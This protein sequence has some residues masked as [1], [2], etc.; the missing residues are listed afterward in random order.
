MSRWMVVVGVSVLM[1]GTCLVAATLARGPGYT[2]FAEAREITCVACAS[3]PAAPPGESQYPTETSVMTIDGGPHLGKDGA[4]AAAEDAQTAAEVFGSSAEA[5]EEQAR[6]TQAVAQTSEEGSENVSADPREPAGAPEPG[7]P[8]ATP[9]RQSGG[10]SS[11][12]SSSGPPAPTVVVLPDTGG[13][14]LG[15]LFSGAVLLIGGGVALAR[16]LR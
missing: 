14:G 15:A 7:T 5:A 12:A 4:K 2:T 6:P 1:I 10:T 11:S 16:V 13:V 8:A 3:Q 9:D